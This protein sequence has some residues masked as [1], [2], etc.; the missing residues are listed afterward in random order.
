MD[1][2]AV[3]AVVDVVAAVTFAYLWPGDDDI[4]QILANKRSGSC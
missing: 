2:V 3:A 4:L 1:A